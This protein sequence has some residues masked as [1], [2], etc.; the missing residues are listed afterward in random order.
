MQSGRVDLAAL[1][2]LLAPRGGGAAAKTGPGPAKP[3]TVE[4]A[5][6]KLGPIATR[7]SALGT[8]QASQS[9]LIQPEIAGKVVRVGFREGDRV[10][11]G[12]VLI[13]LDRS[14]LS[15]EADQARTSLE[16]AEANRGRADTLAKQGTGTVRSRDE[17]QA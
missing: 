17:T 2:G 10:K 16:L 5:E 15:A 4:V 8:L 3:V 6:V 9:V 12:A 13:E 14:I 1:Q 7:V 11:A